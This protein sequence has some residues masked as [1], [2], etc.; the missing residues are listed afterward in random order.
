MIHLVPKFV[1]LDSK[2]AV[3]LW[4]PGMRVALIQILQPSLAKQSARVQ[5]ACPHVI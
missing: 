5:L 4:T 1:F 3:A 2:L